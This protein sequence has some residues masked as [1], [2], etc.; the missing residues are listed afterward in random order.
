MVYEALEARD[1]AAPVF[2]AHLGWAAATAGRMCVSPLRVIF[3]IVTEKA[4]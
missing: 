2:A 1:A 3:N 4:Q